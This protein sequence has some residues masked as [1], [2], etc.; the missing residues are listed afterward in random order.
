[1]T[2]PTNSNP[3]SRDNSP[4]ASP[5]GSPRGSL[6]GRSISLGSAEDHPVPSNIYISPPHSPSPLSSQHGRTFKL[7]SFDKGLIAFVGIVVAGFMA[8][9]CLA[10]TGHVHVTSVD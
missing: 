6:C 9:L 1:M 7:D 10:L 5:V 4:L 2:S 3:T 8:V